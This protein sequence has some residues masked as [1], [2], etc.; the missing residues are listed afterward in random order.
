MTSCETTFVK[1]RYI[2]PKSE[3]LIISKTELYDMIVDEL[4]H[5]LLSQ[6]RFIPLP[7]NI[8][9]VYVS[10]INLPVFIMSKNY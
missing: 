6:K 7:N 3:N 2:K 8:D 9:K 4:N 5:I 10:P 1:E